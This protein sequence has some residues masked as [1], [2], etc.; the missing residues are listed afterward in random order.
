MKTIVL[1]AVSAIALS[2][3][4]RPVQ[5]ICDDDTCVGGKLGQMQEECRERNFV[6]KPVRD[7]DDD[8]DYRRPDR[9][10]DP[11]YPGDDD[12]KEPKDRPKHKKDKKKDR[13]KGNPGNHKDVGAA[14]EKPNGKGGWGK[15]DKGRNK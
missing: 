13:G 6:R 3:C 4:A 2:A 9:D 1:L 7:N 10:P 14:G 8:N 5:I 11:D 12:D 15:G